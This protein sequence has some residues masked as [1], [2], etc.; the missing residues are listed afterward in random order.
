MK[1]FDFSKIKWDE[2]SSEFKYVKP[3]HSI[4]LKSTRFK[5]ISEAVAF[6]EK[7]YG[8][9]MISFQCFERDMPEMEEI[10]L[11]ID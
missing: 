5:S 9:C 8:I 2:T 6:V 7:Q 1:I 11:F 10:E 3:V 4:Q